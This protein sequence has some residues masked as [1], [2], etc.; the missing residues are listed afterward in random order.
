MAD[1]RR[2]HFL[3]RRVYGQPL[4]VNPLD[5]ALYR[6][7]T[8]G[9]I[10]F[11]GRSLQ[12]ILPPINGHSCRALPSQELLRWAEWLSVTFVPPIAVAS[13][14]RCLYPNHAPILQMTLFRF[15]VILAYIAALLA[16][17]FSKS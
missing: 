16:I 4:L 12:H 10:L 5:A 15:R 6:Q 8:S 17:I 1:P 13:R 9:Y 14:W 11:D 2:V 3:C 7:R